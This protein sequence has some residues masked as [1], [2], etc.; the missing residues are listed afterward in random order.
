MVLVPVKTRLDHSQALARDSNEYDS[1]GDIP[2]AEVTF[3]LLFDHWI[4]HFGVPQSIVSDRDT[5]F[6]SKFWQAAHAA[7]ARSCL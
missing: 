4:K 5:Q 1:T 3:Q 2:A 6:M 7:W